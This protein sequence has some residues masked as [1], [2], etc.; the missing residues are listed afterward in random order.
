[1]VL[2]RDLE[3]CWD[4]GSVA[5]NHMTDQLS[6]ILVDQDNVNVV[7][8]D[9]PLEAVFDLADGSICRGKPDYLQG[10]RLDVYLISFV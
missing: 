1:M 9:E 7:T 3:H 8:L 4:G 5:V 2:G 10:H 6:Y